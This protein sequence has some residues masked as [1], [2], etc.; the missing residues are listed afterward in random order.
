MLKVKNTILAAIMALAFT[1]CFESK[2]ENAIEDMG[3]KIE[4]TGEKAVDAMDDAVDEIDP[5]FK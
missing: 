3:E 2:T 5:E 1:A 4:E